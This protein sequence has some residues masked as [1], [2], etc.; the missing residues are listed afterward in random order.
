MSST[1]LFDS[2]LKDLSTN[3]NL[4]KLTVRYINS[5]NKP[6][7]QKLNIYNDDSCKEVLL[8][9][10]SL[11]PTV[12]SD[13]VFAWYEKDGNIQPINFTYPSLDLDNPFTNKT[14]LDTRFISDSGNR[15]LVSPDR[16]IFHNL[17]GQYEIKT[18]YYTT[19]QDYLVYLGLPINRQITDD[20]CVEK[21]K[22]TIKQLY[23]G[24]I[25]KFW[26]FQTRDQMIHISKTLIEKIKLEQL[27]VKKML[28]QSDFVYSKEPAI[29]PDEYD[30][31]LLSL[32]NNDETNIIYLSRLFSDIHLGDMK[33]L[34]VSIPF[35]KITLEDYTTRHCKLLKDSIVISSINENNYVTKELLSTWFK[36]QITSLSTMTLS[37]MNETNSVIFKLY[38]DTRYVTLVIYSNG[39]GN[40]LFS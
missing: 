40:L 27:A 39:L 34:D 20:V 30:V 4:S 29:K 16:T 5:S 12:N 25:V 32:S 6:R 26:P 17:I 24:K 36:S 7:Q 33:S 11:H 31:K 3:H 15:I 21:T 38:K 18:L 14:K 2:S 8:K 28:S 13:Q 10:S 35:T 22:F 19:L 37:Y 1:S 23:D 9:L